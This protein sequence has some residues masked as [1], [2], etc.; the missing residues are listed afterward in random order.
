MSLTPEENGEICA[1]GHLISA[2]NNMFTREIYVEFRV[3]KTFAKS[4]RRVI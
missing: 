3:K 4:K 2:A 1:T